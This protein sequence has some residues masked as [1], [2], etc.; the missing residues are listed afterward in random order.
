MIGY[1][2]KK[3]IGSKNER[4][5]K[6][7]RPMV[8]RI[9]AIEASLQSQPR[10]ALLQKTADWRKRLSAIQDNDELVAALLEILPEAFAVVKTT[11]RRLCGTEIVVRGHPLKWDMIPFDVQ[12]IGAYA[13][14]TGRI[15]EMATGEG[16]TLVATLPVYLNALTGRGVHVVTVNDY[17]AARDGEWMGAVYQ[18]LGLSVG[19]ILHDQEPSVRREQYNCDITYGTNAE[20]GFDYL[21]DNGMATRL[22]DQVQRGH[23]FAIVDEVDSILIDEARVPL[24]IS[25]PAV[26]AADSNE[27]D[28][29]K[30][31]V[32]SLVHAQ[33]K[34]CARF[35]SEAEELLKRLRPA[36]GSNA[37][38]P[39]LLE[40]EIGLLLYKVKMGQPR[41]EG[42][43][44]LLEEPENLRLMNK[45]E[46]EL[47]VDQSK[48][49]LY[50]QKE[51]L[52]FA[53]DE[54][55]HEAD[56]T[57]KGRNFLSPQDPDAFVLP[58]L[59][60]AF[61][62]IDSGPEADVHKR[63][64][65]KT[66][67]Q[68]EFEAKAQRIHC[69][70]QLLKAYCLYLKDVQ[71]VVQENKVIIVDENTGRLMTG[72]RWSDG[73]HQAV[74]AKEGVEVERETQTYATITIQNYFRLYQ[75][76]A[77]MT[78][79]AETEAQEFYDI[80]KLGVLVIPTNRP[81]ARNDAHDTVYK[82]KRE[83][84]SAVVREI[85]QI[86]QQGRPI[87]VGT[88]SVETS[89]HL[90]RL[91]KK[92]G[93][94][95]SVL[96]AKFHQQ[97]AEIVA[98]AGQK[99]V[100]T[101]ATNMAGR[102]TDIKLAPGIPDLGGLHVLGTERH[103]ARR[104]DR[105]L[106][107]RCA[108]QGDPG[109]SHFFI[110]LEDD[111]MRLFGSDK[112]VKYMEKMGL[113]EGQELEHPLLNRSIGTAQKRVEQHNF[114]I[115]KRT[116]EYDD[117]MNKQREV[118]YGFRNEIIRAKDVRDRVMDVMEEVVIQKVD[119]FT[120]PTADVTEWN[121]R[122]LADWVNLNFPLGLPEGEI[123]KAAQSGSE[124]PVKDSIFDGLSAA[125]FAVCNFISSAVRKAY[126]LKVSFENPEALRSIERW[127]IL[128]AIDKL[129]QEHL[130]G[131][132]SLRN[133]IGLRAYGQRDPL[134][135]YKAEAFKL[136]DEL[137][138]NIKTEICHN[139][140]RSASSLMAF[141]QFLRSMPQKTEHESTSA[142]TG[143]TNTASPSGPRPSD[144]VS[145]AADAV[146]KAKPIRTG[147][148]VGRND[149]CPCGSGR[150]YKHCCG[151]N[152]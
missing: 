60:S 96:N 111:L 19:C 37:P 152:G 131:M 45:A 15:A 140:F 98:R 135:E 73:L 80:Y 52:F 48:K 2:I 14:H 89:E 34:L 107:G 8:A 68:A 12:L 132:D 57:E 23:Y 117:V 66:K 27:Y 108:R 92:A 137:M 55:S 125:Q 115:R 44:K 1:I 16:K 31:V 7:L 116:L 53:M 144:V 42:L 71:Y 50:A 119:Q 141:D 95:H 47:H 139:I 93:I 106:R 70:S 6:R 9:N 76:L 75:K 128:S 84:F 102:G 69:I 101:I 3:I 151:K 21:R 78:G 67:L 88:V 103:E 77:G 120:S 43:L 85:Q 81:I 122:G 138:V 149:P 87:L 40:R 18:Y 32:E 113:E 86:H 112:I 114:Q 127:T 146:A 22:E 26:V 94:I 150:K 25:G 35:L 20:F 38:E 145:E 105:Q 110:S 99:S 17:L 104:I 123:V 59:A 56:L 65:A 126:E 46:L 4:E 11:C 136:F 30:P 24:I 143:T 82:T 62:E 118:I 83:K 121:L 72:R 13:L 100:V 64:E 109:S 41:S 97:E 54:K 74:E 49:D 33:E 91:L 51:E 39:D 36:D 147:P 134:I 133:S 90:S 79:T 63:L 61:N 10:E 29:Y 129:W 5:V 28:K 58:D 130:Y 142:F 124:E 148:K